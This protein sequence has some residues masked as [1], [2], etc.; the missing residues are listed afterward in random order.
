MAFSVVSRLY[1]CWRAQELEKLRLKYRTLQDKF[2]VSCNH[3]QHGLK[4]YYCQNLYS[5]Y[6]SYIALFQQPRM[7]VKQWVGQK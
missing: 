7:I 5:C 4:L 1:A 6:K 3:S 2:E